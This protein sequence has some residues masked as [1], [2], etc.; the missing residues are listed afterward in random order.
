LLRR[1]LSFNLKPFELEFR[2]LVETHQS[3]VF[4][5][6]YRILGDRGL[7]EEVAQDVFLAL[8]RDLDRLESDTHVLAWLRRVTVH[9]AL[10]AHRRRAS[11]IEYAAE[12][13]HEER[14]QVL[15]AGENRSAA[16]G[17]TYTSARLERWMSSLSAIQ[18]SVLLLRYQ[19]DMLPG[20]IAAA[21]AMP[22]ATVKSHL[23]RALKLLRS[24]AERQTKEVANG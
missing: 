20:E 23:Q 14:T 9:R 8:Y 15:S 17:R 22:Q 19:E 10:D 2:H 18:K 16:Q 12:E 11:R 5:I 1:P 3:R 21:L 24:Q 13:F 7:A 6:A 4:S